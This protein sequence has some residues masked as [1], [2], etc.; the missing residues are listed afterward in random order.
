MV[1][2]GGAES[3]RS[4]SGDFGLILAIDV[5]AYLGYKE[6]NKFYKNAPSLLKDGGYLIVMYETNFLICML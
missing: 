5:I 6:L 2:R 1:V 3:L 4:I